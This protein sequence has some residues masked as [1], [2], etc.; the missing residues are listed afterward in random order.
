MAE[1]DGHAKFGSKELLEGVGGTLANSTELLRGSVETLLVVGPG[2][3]AK[4]TDEVET[5]NAFS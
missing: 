2:G 1:S 4:T 5:L 3:V